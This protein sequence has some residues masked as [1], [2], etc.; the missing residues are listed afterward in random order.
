MAQVGLGP[1]IVIEQ[2]MKE[3]MAHN[4]ET[5]P[6]DD[7]VTIAVA[8]IFKIVW[9][10]EM[11][12][13]GM[14]KW[15]TALIAGATL[16]SSAAAVVLCHRISDR[17]ISLWLERIG[18]RKTDRDTHARS[19]AASDARSRRLRFSGRRGGAAL[20]NE[21][22]IVTPPDGTARI[23]FTDG[24]FIEMAPSTMVRLSFGSD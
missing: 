13:S 15:E 3:F 12:K 22:T 8:S 9:E 4:G 7:D 20:F 5:K 6:L 23:E 11:A 18:C 2:L 1:K 24:S 14:K 21:D 19:T 10:T 17:K 16:R